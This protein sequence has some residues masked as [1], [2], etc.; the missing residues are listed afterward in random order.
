MNYGKYE[1]ER[2]LKSLHSK[3]GKYAS[4]LLLNIFKYGFHL[5]DVR[6]MVHGKISVNP[7]KVVKKPIKPK[8]TKNLSYFFPSRAFFIKLLQ[9]DP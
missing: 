9:T 5:F 2:R 8:K 7:A 6:R 1:A 4:R 3:S